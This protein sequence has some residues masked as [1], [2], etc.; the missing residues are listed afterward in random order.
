MQR[1]RVQSVIDMFMEHIKKWERTVVGY[2][3]QEGEGQAV[4]D[5]TDPGRPF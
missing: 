5:L 1:P 4:A 3:G 2:Q